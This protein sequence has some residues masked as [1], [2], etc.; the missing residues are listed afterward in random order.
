M[1]STRQRITY[2]VREERRREYRERRVH[3]FDSIKHAF[4][5]LK[6][7][8]A[9]TDVFYFFPPRRQRC[10]ACMPRDTIRDTVNKA[11][12]RCRAIHLDPTSGSTYSKLS[13][14]SIDNIITSP[15]SHII[16]CHFT[17]CHVMS[18]HY[19]SLERCLVLSCLDF[20]RNRWTELWDYKK[21]RCLISLIYIYFHGIV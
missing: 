7:C 6:E 13:M 8:N 20:S 14:Q 17:S 10:H 21:L 2:A 16:S 3:L 1:T 18:C 5:A 15:V 4:S 9:M 19:L 11:F 12:Y